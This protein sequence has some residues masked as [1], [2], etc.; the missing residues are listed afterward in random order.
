MLAIARTLMCQ[1]H[2]VILDEP[3]RGMAVPAAERL[4]GK[5]GELCRRGM[6]ILLVEQNASALELADYLYVMKTGTVAAEG[7]RDEILS[8]ENVRQ[9]FLG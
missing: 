8:Q 7:T 6:T 1:A 9:L 4:F 3:T 5:I 2:T